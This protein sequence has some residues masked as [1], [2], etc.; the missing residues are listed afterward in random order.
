MNFED[1]CYRNVIGGDRLRVVFFDGTEFNLDIG[2]DCY[3]ISCSV[4]NEDG[5]K[6]YP[7]TEAGLKALLLDEGIIDALSSWLD[8][9]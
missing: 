5:A 8:Y 7:K 4:F 6:K 1:I 2:S 3:A 9:E